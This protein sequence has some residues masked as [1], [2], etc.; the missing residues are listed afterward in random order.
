[1]SFNNNILKW[2]EY[3]KKIIEQTKILKHLKE[4]KVAL[5]NDLIN[6]IVTNN[7]VDKSIHIS[8]SNIELKYNTVNNYESITYKYLEKCFKE[9]FTDKKIDL[10]LSTDLLD[11]IK[12]NRGIIKKE[13]IKKKSINKNI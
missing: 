6:Y 2:V 7:L 9:F 12:N 10:E 5:H 1:M 13:C 8:N 3:D 4:K 11:Y